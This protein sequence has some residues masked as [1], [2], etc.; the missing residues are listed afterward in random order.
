MF[1][2]AFGNPPTVESTGQALAAYMRTLLSANSP[3]DR[4]FFG[5]EDKALDVAAE[6]G[7]SVFTGTAGC[8]RC[9]RVAEGHAL[10]TDGSFH[11]TGLGRFNSV[12]KASS[13]EPV[14][15]ELAPGVVVP[16]E[17]SAVRSV[18]EPKANDLGR[19]EVT[20]DPA[21]RWL[22][23]TPSLRNVSLTAPY[24]HDGS[25]STL[26]E[27]VEFYRKGGHPH[28]GIDPLIQ[29]LRISNQDI[30]DLLAFL[31]SLTGDNVQELVRDARSQ[32]VGNPRDG[33][34]QSGS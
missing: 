18:G 9:H 14:M 27:V 11:D 20:G 15:V 16:M 33:S 25:F 34:N 30:D 28:E 26:R 1:L 29:P 8:V 21:D 6:R 24:M 23:K 12:V 32:E 22:F 17:R 13:R 10:F 3:F 5:A 31:E 19:Y 7:F 2:E 4:W